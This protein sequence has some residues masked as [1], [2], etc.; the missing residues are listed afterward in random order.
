M[1]YWGNSPRLD[2]ISFPHHF[3]RSMINRRDFLKTSASA[4][5]ALSFPTI[6]S[7]SALGRGPR[8]AASDRIALAFIG[9]GNMGTNHVRGFLE[10]ERV[11]VVAV[12]DVNRMTPGYW[13]GA[14]GGREPAK[15]IVDFHYG[16]YFSSGR[17]SACDSYEDFRDVLAR[18]DIDAVVISTPDHWHGIQIVRAAE[19]GKDIYGEKPLSLT[20]RQGR[21]MSD[22]VAANNVVFQTGSQQRSDERFRH[23]CELVLNGRIGTLKTVTCGL[24]PG[25]PDFGRTAHRQ[26]PEV[27]PAGF[28]Y[29][30][31]LGPAPEAPYSPARCHVNF[32]WILDYSGGQVT[33]WGGHHPDIAHWGMGMAESGPVAIRNA[34]GVFP[35]EGLYNTA[36]EYYFE[37]VYDTGAVM[38]VTSSEPNG[39][40]F[41]GTD[42][43][44][45]VSR[46]EHQ[47]S[48]PK[49]WDSV[50]GENEIRLPRSDDH[51]RNFIDSV[52]SRQEPVAPVEH[53]HRSITVAHLG[54]IAMLLG[55]DLKWDPA[56]ETFVGD[57]EANAML[58]RPMRE[59]WTL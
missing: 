8:P 56:R 36:T 54:N 20:V 12:C 19:A 51:R 37:A 52:L 46:N 22:A 23:A 33:D 13:N 24:P 21:A 25:H 28:N 17:Y 29:D 45:F 39:V 11:Q 48:D 38:I 35:T 3:L 9:T 30:F 50:I 53:A 34:R 43:W 2:G 55:R 58:D 16:R 41:E 6:V 42:G 49:I 18:S 31:W 44:I 7:A 14:I 4:A 47:V 26:E 32:R 10:D 40:R 15:A 1:L 27:I 57:A 5:G 59:P